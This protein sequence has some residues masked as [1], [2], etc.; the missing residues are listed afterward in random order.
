MYYIQGMQ[1]SHCSAKVSGNKHC[2]LIFLI[3]LAVFIESFER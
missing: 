1:F 2:F 3:S